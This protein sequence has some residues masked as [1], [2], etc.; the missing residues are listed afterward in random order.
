MIMILIDYKLLLDNNKKDIKKSQN[1]SLFIYI[2]EAAGYYNTNGNDG[3]SSIAKMFK[4]FDVDFGITCLE[5]K[6]QDYMSA[7]DQESLVMDLVGDAL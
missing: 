1:Q 2:S 4:E 6:G 3:D 5:M 7:S